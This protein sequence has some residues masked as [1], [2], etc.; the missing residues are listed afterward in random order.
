[1]PRKCSICES[2]T[3]GQ[4]P[5]SVIQV[6]SRPGISFRELSETLGLSRSALYRH[7]RGKHDGSLSRTVTRSSGTQPECVVCRMGPEIRAL[8]FDARRGEKSVRYLAVAVAVGVSR[9]AMRLHLR[10]C[11]PA[12][13]GLMRC[14]PAGPQIFRPAV[15]GALGRL[16]QR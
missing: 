10:N 14:D 11:V 9:S 6:G 16:K 8:V 12:S 1:M 5:P 13:F 7:I 2:E 4:I 15:I 3:K